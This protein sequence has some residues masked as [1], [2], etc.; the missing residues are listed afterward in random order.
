MKVKPS[1]TLILKNKMLLAK[2]QHISYPTGVYLLRLHI[3]YHELAEQ[4]GAVYVTSLFSK[5]TRPEDISNRQ[6]L[7]TVA[8]NPTLCLEL[9]PCV[10]PVIYMNCPVKRQEVY[11]I[12]GLLFTSLLHCPC[13]ACEPVIVHS[14]VPHA[15]G[16]VKR[17]QVLP[18]STSPPPAAAHH[19]PSHPA[20]PF[21]RSR[22]H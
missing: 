12:Y 21:E 14:R 9:R 5:I 19:S 17:F 4:D 6:G 13:L 1:H 11:F 2:D 10:V 16:I 7:R 8:N 20:N 15:S 18:Q 22:I 3:F